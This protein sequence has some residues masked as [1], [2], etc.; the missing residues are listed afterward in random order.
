MAL[1]RNFV[2]S[3]EIFVRSGHGGAGAVHF[4]STKYTIKGG[5]DGGNG[6][7]GGDVIFVGNGN[8]STLYHLYHKRHFRA[9]DG[10]CGGKEDC[11]GHSAKDILI[12][13]PLGTIIR[14]KKTNEI[15]GTI[16]QNGKK[17]IILHGGKGGLGNAHF[18]GPTNQAPRYAQPGM[19]GDEKYLIIELQLLADVGLVGFPNIG[20][21]T[22][23][24]VVSNAKPVVANYPFTTLTPQL[25]MVSHKGRSFVMVDLPG[26]IE[27]ASHGKGLGIQFLKHIERCKI[28]LILIDATSDSPIIDYKV[29]RNELTKYKNEITRKKCVIAMSKMDIIGDNRVSI[30]RSQFKEIGISPI[31]ISSVQH[32]NIDTLLDTLIMNI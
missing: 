22:L 23:L 2:D 10:K 5:P 32:K 20:K 28:I 25:G 17:V 8:L 13:V 29:L 1:S 24:S 4:R 7:K 11:S 19:P 18:R 31:F 12:E 9:N 21:S 15:L 16:N 14:D 3:V 27:G 26:I 6:G 30:I